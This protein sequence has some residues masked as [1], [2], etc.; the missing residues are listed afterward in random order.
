MGILNVLAELHQEPDMKLN[1]KFEIEVLCKSLGIEIR[2]LKPNGILKDEN[3]FKIDIYQLSYQTSSDKRNIAASLPIEQSSQVS[4]RCL[5][6]F[7][8][9]ID[10][11]IF[12]SY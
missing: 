7:L 12:M 6:I 10:F 3:I 1:L 2:D 4:Y 5:L 8:L 9:I 11:F